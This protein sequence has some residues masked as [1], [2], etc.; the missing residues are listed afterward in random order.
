MLC[1]QQEIVHHCP[2]LQE[3]IHSP[4]D[5]ETPENRSPEHKEPLL[6]PERHQTNYD[7]TDCSPD[8]RDIDMLSEKLDIDRGENKPSYEETDACSGEKDPDVVDTDGENSADDTDH[9]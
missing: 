8:D 7:C 2:Q 1:K 3:I 5:H 6:D 4:G 9:Y